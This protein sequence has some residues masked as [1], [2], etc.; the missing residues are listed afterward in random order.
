MSPYVRSVAALFAALV[1]L[2]AACDNAPHAGDSCSSPGSMYAHGDTFLTCS[3]RGVWV[4]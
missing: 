1:L 3:P 2:T 4:K